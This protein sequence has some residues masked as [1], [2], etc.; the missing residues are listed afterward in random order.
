M[1]KNTLVKI[2]DNEGF[3]KYIND[4]EEGSNRIQSHYIEDFVRS[5]ELTSDRWSS[6]YLFVMYAIIIG[7]ANNTISLMTELVTDLSGG[8]FKSYAN[9]KII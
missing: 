2:S 6:K 7:S 5:Q 3:V 4:N 8:N 9:I 1:E